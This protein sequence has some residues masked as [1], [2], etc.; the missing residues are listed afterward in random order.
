VLVP[1]GASRRRPGLRLE[2]RAQQ[3]LAAAK[4]AALRTM[5]RFL[6]WRSASWSIV[7]GL[8]RSTRSVPPGARA[9]RDGDESGCK[10]YAVAS[11]TTGEGS[12]DDGYG[13]ALDVEAAV[14]DATPP[15]WRI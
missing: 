14:R 9:V 10:N 15:S 6:P 4:S 3:H 13:V 12:G 1:T 7:S 11:R 5:P 8:G 2:E